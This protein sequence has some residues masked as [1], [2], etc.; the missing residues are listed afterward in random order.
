MEIDFKYVI[1]SNTAI[2]G[3]PN[4]N[5]PLCEEEIWTQRDPR[6]ERR[7]KKYYWGHSENTISKPR[8]KTS[9]EYKPA[10]T[11]ILDV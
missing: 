9:E 8:R 3:G 1:Q 7:Q 2:G 10:N 6:D 4:P 5:L 11:W